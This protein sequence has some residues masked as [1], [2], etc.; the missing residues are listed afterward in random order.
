[1]NDLARTIL[2]LKSE[3]ASIVY[4]EAT[5]VNTVALEGAAT[6]AELPA[7]T[8]V[9]A[10]DYC[11]VLQQGADRLILGPV[12][13]GGSLGP[14]TNLSLGSG[15]S[16]YGSG[17]GL[18]RYRKFRDDV[19]LEGLVLHGSG[20]VGT[21][22]GTLPSGFRPASGSRKIFHLP[23]NTS[24]DS[25]VTARVDIEPDGDVVFTTEFGWSGVV[26]YLSLD[27]VV[28]STS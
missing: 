20:G 23:A 1:V 21:T 22:V 6:A 17:Y 3:G 4:G 11:A 26:G 9:L 16:N 27:G 14:W 24:V 2:A 19:H 25:S 8:P 28:F 10:G 15:W 12:G 5:A 18:A 7:L 13:A